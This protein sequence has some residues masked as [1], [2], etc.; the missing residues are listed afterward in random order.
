MS[1]SRLVTALNFI[2]DD[3]LTEA[4]TYSSPRGNQLKTFCARASVA[5]CVCLAVA[6]VLWAIIT[7]SSDGVLLL[8]PIETLP[9][10]TEEL[11]SSMPGIVEIE[12]NE[13]SSDYFSAQGM[14]AFYPDKFEDMT[15]DEILDHFGIVLDLSTVLPNMREAED[16]R[17]GLYYLGD[18]SVFD[19]FTFEYIDIET[20]Q[21]IDILFSNGGLHISMIN[22]AYEHGLQKSMLYD[23]EIL[24]A[25]YTDIV[26]I[27]TY[28]AEFTDGNL[29]VVVVA[30]D[31]SVEDFIR[32]LEYLA[33]L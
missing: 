30:K 29:G 15:R 18:G 31:C 23:K 32:T 7:A 19:E 3:L 26:D 20:C 4:I 17:Y 12:I 33:Q 13:I 5:A 1:I 10:Q 9:H 28:Y 25:H 16:T 2:D 21:R 11:Q 8:Y 24:I 22:E 14:F 27:S 6:T